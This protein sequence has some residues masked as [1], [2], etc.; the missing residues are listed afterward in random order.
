MQNHVLQNIVT[1][2]SI[3]SFTTKQ[4]N[5]ED[6]NQ[7]MEAAIYAPSGMN[8]Q[9]WHFTILR[10]KDLMMTLAQVIARRLRID[11]TSYTFYSPDVLVIASNDRD[12]RNGFMDCACALQNIFLMSHELGIGSVWIN[13]LR[14]ICD[15]PEVRPVLDQLGIPANHVVWG[16]AALGYTAENLEAAPRMEGTIHYVV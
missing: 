3:R 12:N 15:E 16:M 2:R 5:K 13:Q 7:I 4:I 14:E 1:R 8:R 6:L 10:N 11:E 9:S